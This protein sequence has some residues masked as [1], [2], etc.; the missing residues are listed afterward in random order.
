MRCFHKRNSSHLECVLISYKMQRANTLK[1]IVIRMAT[2]ANST[3]KLVGISRKQTSWKSLGVA[4]NTPDEVKINEFTK[5]A[6]LSIRNNTHVCI[7]CIVVAQWKHC[8]AQNV[9]DGKKKTNCYTHSSG[10]YFILCAQCLK[11][12]YTK[13]TKKK[14]HLIFTR[15]RSRRYG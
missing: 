8:I 13:N 3:I 12:S 15:S 9:S 4:L 10:T 5:S 7:I 6:K 14:I 2:V 1:P 11:N